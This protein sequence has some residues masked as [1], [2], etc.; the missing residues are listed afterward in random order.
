MGSLE[1][2]NGTLVAGGAQGNYGNIYTINITTGAATLVGSTGI[3]TTITGLTYGMGV[4][5]GLGTPIGGV[6]S[7]SGITD[8]GNGIT[9]S[10]DPA[11]AGVGVHAIT[12]TYTNTNGCTNAAS[13]NIEV[14]ALPTVTYTAPA[15]LCID[16]GVQ[17]GLGGGIA[18]GGVYS[19]PGVTDD[20]NG[21]TYSFDPATAGVGVHTLTYTFTDGNVCTNAA[22]DSIEVFALPTVNYTA[23]A[24]LCIDAGVQAGLGG[25]TA[26]G[27]V[28]SGAGVTDDGNGMT[29]AFDPAAAGV[30]VHTIT[31]TFTNANGC[32]DAASDD[33][34]V[35]T[36]PTVT[37]M[38]PADLCIDAGVQTGL[39]GGTATGGVYSGTGVTDDGNGT[40]YSFDPATAGVG[41]HTLTYTFT[42]GNVCTNAASD[43]IEVLNAD[44]TVSQ[45]VDV[46]TA[47]QA[48]ATYQWY[49]C[50]NTLLSSET[51]QSFTATALGDYKVV[52]T[53]SSCVVESSC[54]SVTTLGLN[55]FDVASKF[56]MYPNPSN[57]Q[58]KIKSTM[59]GDFEIVNLLG[60]T[61][62]AFEVKANVETTVFIGE[63][64]E[65]LYLVKATNRSNIASKKLIIKK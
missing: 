4:S 13:D 63:L 39:G 9:Y 55:T 23:P 50:P 44:N 29:Y 54:V 10:F 45:V 40:T 58:V 1:F 30:G 59:G 26:T 7:G 62:K 35:F 43:D 52:I 6:Y 2:H 60:Q 25:G 51:G 65:G 33:V 38:A 36:L 48:G 31:Y 15:D 32:A 61:V 57:G 27:G 28:Y 47:N 21:T 41:V 16:S 53:N 8:D 37:Y 14:F 3:N 49:E 42:D 24:D 5:Q 12:Y 22:S 17:T 20:G 11:A 46:L 56:S 18:T 64:S 19:G 34:E